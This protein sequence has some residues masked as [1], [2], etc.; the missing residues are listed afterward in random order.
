LAEIIEYPDHPWFLAVQFHPEFKSK[1][2]RPHP[3]FKGFAEAAVTH[4]DVLSK[5]GKPSVRIEPT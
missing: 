4:R 2:L 3:I 5:S 1:P